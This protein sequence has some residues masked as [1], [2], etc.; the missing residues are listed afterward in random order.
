M[1]RCVINQ[2]CRVLTAATMIFAFAASA[3]AASYTWDGTNAGWNSINWLNGSGG[4]VV[5]GTGNGH[6][7]DSYLISSG[8][9]NFSNGSD[10]F[11]N[12]GSGASPAITVASGGVLA[13]V[14]D[15]TTITQLTLSGGTLLSNGGANG[16]YPGFGAW[17]TVNITGTSASYLIAGT[18]SN[19]GMDIGGT[20]NGGNITFNVTSPAFIVAAPLWNYDNYPTVEQS[21]LTKT[22]SG[23]I[24][25]TATDTYTNGTI[26]SNGVLS[27]ANGSL[28]TTGNITMNGGVLQWYG[29]NTQDISS[30]LA[31]VNSTTATF[32]TNGNN[33]TFGSA[34]GGGTSGSLVTVGSGMLTLA[35]AN[36]YTGT[37][38]ISAGTLAL[39]NA[40]A[41]A[42]ST[43]DTSGSGALSFLGLTSGTFGGLQGT[44][45]LSL[46]NTASAVVPLTVGGNGTTTIFSGNLSGGSAALTKIGVGMLTLAGSNTY[47]GATLVTGGSLNLAAGGSLT[48]CGNINTI[49]G[50]VLVINGNVSM[51]ASTA[52]GIGSGTSAAGSTGTT[53]VNTGGVLTSGG[54]NCYFAVGGGFPGFAGQGSGTL[55][56]NGGLV[57]VGAAGTASSGPGSTDATALWL[58][59]YGGSGST[60]NLT[61]G[62]L[63]TARPIVNGT[64]ANPAY[65]N[66]N[67]GTLQAAAGSIT[68][69]NSNL[70][71]N[72][73]AGGATIDTQGFNA[74]VAAALLNSGG[75]G[76][77]KVGSGMLTLTGAN[78][79]S[80][81][82][83]ITAGTL[84][85]GSAGATGTLGNGSGSVSDNGVLAFN[86]TGAV[87][88]S[89]I[90]S[91][92]GSLLQIGGGT[93]TLSGSNAYTGATTVSAGVLVAGNSQALGSGTLSLVG[94]TLDLAIDSSINPYNTAV[95][96]NTTILS[97]RATPGSAG[98]THTLGT[99][100]IGANTL[101]VNQ[102]P[103]VTSGTAAVAF[104][105]LTM[106][107]GATMSPAAGTALTL[108][109]VSG[110]Q[111]LTMSGAGRLILSGSGTNQLS[112]LY[113]NGGETDLNN[114]TVNVSYGIAALSE[115]SG[116]L[117]LNSGAS[118][119]ATGGGRMTNGATNSF[120]TLN[121]GATI[122]MAGNAS[123]NSN[124]VGVDSMNGT[125]NVNGGTANFTG[126][127]TAHEG[128]LHIGNNQGCNGVL[129]VNGGV[130][131]VGDFLG[132]ATYWDADNT[133][134]VTSSGT[135]AIYGGAVN[136]GTSTDAN[137]GVLYLENNA[138][139]ST[140]VATVNLSGGTLSLY[141]ITS[142][143]GGTKIVNFSGG[144]LLATNSNAAF[145]S[146]TVGATYNVQNGGAIFN[147]NGFNVTV[148]L[149][150]VHY[151]LATTDSLTKIG[152][153]M[154]TLNA[155]NT[156]LGGT[157]VSAG[158]LALSGGS[159]RLAT[160]GAIAVSGGVL[161]LGGNNQQT[162]GAISLAGGTIQNGTLTAQGTPFNVQ[163]GSISAVL[164][165]NGAGLT[166]SGS[167][168]VTL[169]AVNTYTGPTS[170]NAGTLQINPTGQ[171][172]AASAISV[173]NSA[174]LAVTANAN[175]PGNVITVA[176]GG[177]LSTTGASGSFSLDSGSLLTLGRPSSPAT[178][179]AGNFTL[180][181][182]TVNVG[183]TNN[184][185]TATFGNNLTLSGGMLEFDLS[186]NPAAGNDLVAVGG[187]LNLN[188]STNLAVNLTNANLT[189]GS[190]TLFAAADVIGS[191]SNLS[192]I[193]AGGATRQSF[194]LSATSGTSVTLN[195]AGYAANLTWTGSTNGTWSL[196]GSDLNWSNPAPGAAN[197]DQFYNADLVNFNDLAGSGSQTITL[198]QTLSP[199]A[200]TVNN[201]ATAY[202]F[203]G[204]GN[205]AGLSTTLSKSG[206]GLL[207]IATS[208]NSFGGATTISGGTIAQGVANAL[209]PATALSVAAAATFDLGGYDAQVSSLTGQGTVTN[210]GTSG[211]NTLTAGDVTNTTFSGALLDGAQALVALHKTGA[212]TLVLNGPNSYSGATTI[213]AGTLQ[214]G[215]GDNSG[216]TLGS[217]PITDNGTLV[218]C[219]SDNITLAAAISGSGSF[220]HAGSGLV[221]L[222]AS[223][224]YTGATGIGSGTLQIGT[225]GP[226]PRSARGPSPTTVR[227][228]STWAAPRRS[229]TSVAADP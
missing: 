141:Q 39:N 157:T 84:Q 14:N 78:T 130:V 40:G 9:V 207:T 5:G 186:N 178:D 210:S 167:G 194:T 128:W 63:S 166:M 8:T 120:L 1:T 181:G 199:A 66:F 193:G 212:G 117:V 114:T 10:T 65:V 116:T 86:R 159:N 68:I 48:G 69:L 156:Y 203:S 90:I 25:L 176:A 228:S 75:G 110:N 98:I 70:T 147:T 99:L 57:R 29:N 59:A 201:S 229:A 31:M 113:F 198:A 172:N 72:V 221:V 196:A 173:A 161:D 100:T 7:G 127:G 50:G 122:T 219:R 119:V 162:S 92:S 32:D 152:S 153:G 215:V 18:G 197:P 204:T 185:A 79:Y 222:T 93:T 62:T 177:T 216:G 95:S 16:T 55:N 134:S 4:T 206:N 104:G 11:G 33:V 223:N 112:T 143:T 53:T 103:N 183:G 168:T 145:I 169:S 174:T 142:G 24:F 139:G 175:L 200:V 224:I 115:G 85:I 184:A 188:S 89:G 121:T 109:T 61:A 131:N 211:F 126:V 189:S 81:S 105:N 187:T 218:F 20:V 13:S 150:L 54:S 182:G 151:P 49:G 43:L 52:F 180:G 41:L 163:S 3:G 30:R 155:A 160:G 144:T 37:T 225:G 107:A 137:S 88:L 146:G 132:V 149:P 205:I 64:P 45:N 165:D 129:N 28:G 138:A 83:T 191:T 220:L 76:L 179:V 101:T 38:L 21:G 123:S 190:Y 60:I 208:G 87:G 74:A 135:L 125:M 97:D 44:G 158:T 27:F 106:T 77:T 170:I 154:L 58:D 192:L 23:T 67:G 6:T 227:W 217:A 213:N 46:T 202:T 136:L 17:G 124:Y 214:F 82:T 47:T 102:G 108:G 140:G 42:G 96:G 56:V 209:S 19:N 12:A 118:V 164:A 73:Q 22:G 195:V 36:T 94:G 171:I 51:A 148:P 133:N 71:V 15:Y 26:I 35:A 2:A 226:A 91:G 80:G 34:F 111:Q